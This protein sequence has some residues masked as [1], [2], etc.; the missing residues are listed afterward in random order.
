MFSPGRYPI[1][2]IHSSA[3][4]LWRKLSVSGNQRYSIA[5]KEVSSQARLSQNDWRIQESV[6]VGMDVVD[7]GTT[8][9]LSV[10]GVV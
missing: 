6:S 5:I 7:C 1:L 8:F 3:L 4:L 2:W 10:S 9:S